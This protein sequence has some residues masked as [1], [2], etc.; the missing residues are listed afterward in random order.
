[1]SGHVK[2]L[3]NIGYF[4]CPPVS[5][6][7]PYTIFDRQ[8][9]VE[10]LTGGKIRFE[11]N[12]EE[13]V[14][15]RGTVFWHMAGDRTI[16]RTFADDPYRCVV[17]LFQVNENARPGPRV[18]TWQNPDETIAFCDECHQAFHAG[19][20][21]LDALGDYAYSTIRWKALSDE[22]G[23]AL[24][25]PKPLQTACSYIEQHLGEE[26]SLDRIAARS[27]ISR[28]YLF[29][30]FRK[31][32]GKAPFHFIQ[33]RRIGRAKIMLTA[34]E[35]LSIKEIAMNCGFSELEVFYRQFK[36]QSGLTPAGYRRKYSVRFLQENHNV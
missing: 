25:Y 20:A 2:S 14:F 13:K 15:T 5:E 17:F 27:G 1:M 6:V 8:E 31:Y 11:I 23:S 30:L 16:C 33:E 26:L 9:V 28:P 22:T 3:R 32:F 12:G 21:D 24:E 36:K 29:A 19:N 18:S 4:A 7:K 10:I 35:E 34:P